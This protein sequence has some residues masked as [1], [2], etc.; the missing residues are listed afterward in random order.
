MDPDVHGSA[1]HRLMREHLTGP[2][3]AGAMH[4]RLSVSATGAVDVT[5][6]TREPL[7]LMAPTRSLDHTSLTVT[8][9]VAGGATRVLE[10]A[11]GTEAG[12]H[13]PAHRPPADAVTGLAAPF[14]L[15][16]S[17]AQTRGTNKS[18][19]PLEEIP[20]HVEVQ[21]VEGVLGRLLYLLGAEKAR[22]RRQ[23]REL[24]RAR[25]L[26]GAHD[27]AL[28]RMGAELGVPRLLD[29]IRFREPT[30]E[31]RGSV[32][33]EFPFGERR[34]GPGI[35]GEVTAEARREPDRE[36][37]RR[38]AIY[39]PW[40]YPSLAH[41]RMLLNGP[42]GPG[43]PNAGLLG[44]AG[45]TARAEVSDAPNP[46]A[47]AVHL[48]A[49]GTP[50]LRKG[51]G[52]HIGRTALVWPSGGVKAQAI[53][54][55]R[56][57][58]ESILEAVD[59]LRARLR[60]SFLLS[61]GTALAPMLAQVLDRVSRCRRA[62][63]ADGKWRVLRA[64]DL[65]GGSRYELGLGADLKPPGAAE[66]DALA[67][68]LRDGD[69]KLPAEPTLAEPD[70]AETRALLTGTVPVDA[71]DD[72]DGAWLLE[73]CGLRTVHRVSKDVLYVS[74]VPTFGLTIGG[75]SETS[76]GASVAFEARYHAAG[77]PGSHVLIVRGLA[78]GVKEWA[79][80]G[81]DPWQVLTPSEAQKAWE[82]A[83]VTPA[84][85]G[86]VLAFVGLPVVKDAATLAAKLQALPAELVATLRLATTTAKRVT[87]GRPEA[88]EELRDLLNVV[89]GQGL[90]SALLLVLGEEDVVVV[91]AG[92]ALPLAG[93]NLAERTATRFRWYATRIWPVAAPF[94]AAD[95]P[96][97]G[98]LGART[99]F[100]PPGPGLYAVVALG[101]IR[102]R[103]GGTE[104]YEFS[105]ELPDGATLTLLQ[106]EYLM[107]LLAHI[108]P[109]GTR[110]DT[111]SLRR[112]HVDLDGDGDAEPVP[113]SVSRTYRQFRRARFRGR[114]AT[115]PT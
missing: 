76:I 81:H 26:D 100:A 10:F 85:A 53:H 40:L 12:A 63:G 6:P 5:S 9:E 107:N 86:K 71:A 115:G 60:G 62:L 15:R 56:Y 13:L 3:Q 14:S 84:A 114:T 61:A 98:Y 30:P 7:V 106:Y 54:D 83:V 92:I 110:V 68:R 39:R 38:L 20:D 93:L 99:K 55:A 48:V 75:P 29:T 64:R 78:E 87:A 16:L 97:I 25:T 109:M 42:G 22:L 108:H 45:V 41:V 90:S 82:A 112:R 96:A 51:F 2:L 113:S 24:A 59:A 104:P 47:V 65:D 73:A 91:F 23:A 17:V 101:Q 67:Q 57:L 49:V 74:H 37:R 28:D 46:S 103:A 66:L 72:P 36:Y 70:P 58:P 94:T 102:A 89:G 79:D 27:D 43:E 8:V 52:E 32:F 35:S 31:E 95:G 1:S 34:F 4:S 69:L 21:L 18:V 50:G 80:L 77:E 111:W 105:V 11:P 19:V 44:E 33:G 88:I